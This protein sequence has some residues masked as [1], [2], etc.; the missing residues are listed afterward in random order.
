MARV[1]LRIRS[2]KGCRHLHR[3]HFVGSLWAN[4][5]NDFNWKDCKSC[6]C[7]IDTVNLLQSMQGQL[8]DGFCLSRHLL[9]NGEFEQLRKYSFPPRLTLNGRSFLETDSTTIHRYMY[10]IM[11]GVLTLPNYSFNQII[12]NSILNAEAQM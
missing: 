9:R 8:H 5:S 10:E 11:A 7:L 3:R 12:L 6:E 1:G 4:L 2:N